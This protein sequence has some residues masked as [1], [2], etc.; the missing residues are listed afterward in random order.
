M[1]PS[2]C[3]SNIRHLFFSLYFMKSFHFISPPQFTFLHDSDWIFVPALTLSCLPVLLISSCQGFRPRSRSVHWRARR[4]PT[5][6]RNASIS[7]RSAGPPRRHCHI[8]G[9]S[10]HTGIGLLVSVGLACLRRIECTQCGSVCASG[11]VADQCERR[12]RHC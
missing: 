5:A 4:A 12:A 9:V 2:V 6:V 11:A 3:A 1:D 7:V 10:H 8:S